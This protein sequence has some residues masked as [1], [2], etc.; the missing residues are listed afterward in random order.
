[1]FDN[2]PAAEATARIDEWEHALQRRAEQAQSLAQRTEGLFATARSDD[3]LVEVTVSSNGQLLDLRLD[4]DIR[5][6]SAAT[7]A[8]EIVATLRRARADLLRQFDEATAETIGAD[9]E[10]GRALMRS[11][12]VRLDSVD[13]PHDNRDGP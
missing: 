9:S 6:Q 12:R 5:H 10:T 1:M 11:I 13:A 8:R 3:R 7:T 2:E 4:E